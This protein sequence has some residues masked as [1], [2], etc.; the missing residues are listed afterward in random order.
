MNITGILFAASQDKNPTPIIK[1]PWRNVQRFVQRVFTNPISLKTELV[2]SG[3]M[4][5]GCSFNNRHKQENAIL[6]SILFLHPYFH[7]QCMGKYFKKIKNIKFINFL[8]EISFQKIIGIIFI[9]IFR[10]SLVSFYSFLNNPML[11]LCYNQET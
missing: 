11:F 2:F 5:G 3:Y 10:K 1:T 4:L 8:N 7:V 9:V 6:L